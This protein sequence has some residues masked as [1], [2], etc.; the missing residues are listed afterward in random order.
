MIQNGMNARL[1]V[2]NGVLLAPQGD[3]RTNTQHNAL[4]AAESIERTLLL[5]LHGINVTLAGLELPNVSRSGT[6]VD[7]RGANI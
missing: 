2:V 1:D 3:R 5:R 4:Q 7:R 6:K